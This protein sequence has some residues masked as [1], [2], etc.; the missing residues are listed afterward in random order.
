MPYITTGVMIDLTDTNTDEAKHKLGSRFV[1]TDGTEY[2]YV[3]A[4][5]AITAY[6]VVAITSGFL[7]AS[8][9]KTLADKGQIVGFAQTAFTD[10]YYGW[11]ALKGVGIS[12]RLI[13]G[14]SAEV[15][16][17]TTGTS[18]ALGSA[19]TSQTQIK[20]VVALS[21]NSAGSTVSRTIMATYPFTV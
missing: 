16:L 21:A 1:G 13:D 8:M 18:G 5:G 6:D 11:V 14:T 3:K 2:M 7:A 12:A 19:S 9:T 4:S 10:T 20:G 15:A 17:Y